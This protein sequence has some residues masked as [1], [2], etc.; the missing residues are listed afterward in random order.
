MIPPAE[1]APGPSDLGDELRILAE[2]PLLG[3]AILQDDRVM[4]ANPAA[5]EISGYSLAEVRAWST[6]DFA[7][8]V[9]PDDLPFAAERARQRREGDPASATHTYRI[10]HKSG[11]VRWVKQHA[12]MGTYRG[13]PANP[14]AFVDVT[15]RKQV[16]LACAGQLVELTLASRVKDD[17]LASMS[18][19]LRTPLNGVLG[20]SEALREGVYGP[21]DA[22][23]EAVIARIEDRGRHLLSL[24][25]DI[26]DLARIDAGTAPLELGP[27]AIDE[28][29][30]AALRLV[31][32]AAKR[33]RHSV[34]LQVR[35][36]LVT[37]IADER[38][39]K[40]MLVNLLDNAIKFT[41][42]EG[43]VRL[44]AALS[45]DAQWVRLSVCDTSV[46]IAPEDLPRLF[47]RFV[48]LDASLSRGQ[49]G[50]GLGL[51]LTRRLAD[52]HGGRVEVTSDVGVG[53]CFTLV[54]P[55]R[56]A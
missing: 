8:L 14:I 52:L 35:D 10:V 48:Q 34:S 6:I 42:S 16:E 3:L 44:L 25:T 9:H 47:E 19:E 24:I 31:Y 7:R 2:Q 1:D 56:P 28:V 21:L 18:H 43:S 40:Q 22:R 55:R 32:A 13:R 29:C 46:G 36:A 17:F 27:V 23:Q 20:L 39:L 54:L 26:L 51:A 38:R 41:P 37:V 15:D 12:W 4:Y 45:D 50:A 49:P 30:A 53:S 33:K 5:A 11:A